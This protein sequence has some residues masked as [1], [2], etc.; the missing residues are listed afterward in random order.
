MQIVKLTVTLFNTQVEDDVAFKLAEAWEHMSGTF[1]MD[2]SN[3]KLSV[4]SQPEISTKFVFAH[5]TK[6]EVYSR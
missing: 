1:M 2:V 6:L 3:A 5:P 4:A